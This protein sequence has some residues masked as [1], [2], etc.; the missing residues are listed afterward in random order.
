[1]A[2]RLQLNWSENNAEVENFVMKLLLL[3]EDY[4]G[5]VSVFVFDISF[6]IT[7]DGIAKF[8]WFGEEGDFSALVME[9][10]G[11]SLDDIRVEAGGKFD[12]LVVK[13]L[14]IQMITRLE[15]IHDR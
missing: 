13:G 15:A 1:M 11:S 8:L 7:I 6:L 2:V 4:K 9:F 12:I 14:A 5:W 10:L 3:Y